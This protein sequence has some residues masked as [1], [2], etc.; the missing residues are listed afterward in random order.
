MEHE[1]RGERAILA[2]NSLGGWLALLYAAEHPENVAGLVLENSGGL[3]FDFRNLTFAASNRAE[4]EQIVSIVYGPDM[5]RMPGYILADMVRRSPRAAVHRMRD[6][7]PEDHFLDENVL[8]T[9]KVPTAVIWGDSDGIL[10]MEYGERLARFIPGA[11][12]HPVPRAGHV[13]HLEKPAEFARIVIDEFGGATN[14][15]R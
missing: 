7:K 13:P 3:E 11:S 14:G 5:P 12:F 10:P 1:S 6:V 9:I 2:G 4:A 8:Q 15:A